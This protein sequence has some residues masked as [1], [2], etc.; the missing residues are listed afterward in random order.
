MLAVS[1]LVEYPQESAFILVAEPVFA[2]N[3]L[4]LFGNCRDMYHF[5]SRM[6]HNHVNHTGAVPLATIDN[7]SGVFLACH[8][9]FHTKSTCNRR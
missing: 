4:D 9:S 5:Q 8:S 6:H 2:E 1:L 7:V 3:G